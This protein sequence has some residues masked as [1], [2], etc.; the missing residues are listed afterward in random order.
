MLSGTQML[1]HDEEHTLLFESLTKSHAGTFS[2]LRAVLRLLAVLGFVS[3]L[4]AASFAYWKVLSVDHD[5]HGLGSTLQ[6][7]QPKTMSTSKCAELV[8]TRKD[9]KLW[10]RVTLV[11]WPA[12]Q[13]SKALL[14]AFGVFRS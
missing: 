8:L 13:T 2:G 4:A 1:E 12:P 10:P 9:A 14:S 3:A 6:S 5:V 11:R 7:L